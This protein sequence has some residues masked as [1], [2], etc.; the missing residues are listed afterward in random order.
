MDSKKERRKEI[1]IPLLSEAGVMETIPIDGNKII[2]ETV[3]LL[4]ISRSGVFI[5][6]IANLKPK[7]Y[8]N[9]KLSLPGDL[10]AIQIQ[11][12]IVWK[13]WAVTKAQK[14]MHVGFGVKFVEVSVGIQKILDA[15]V[16][17]LR[18]KQIITVSKR[19]IE[20]FFG[21]ELPNK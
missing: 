7:S 5:K 21:P 18:N 20:E 16:V 10:G 1:R 17:Y 6:S 4:D 19:I 8:I 9:L 14:D 2:V 13:R 3:G 15:Y 12:Q 11:G